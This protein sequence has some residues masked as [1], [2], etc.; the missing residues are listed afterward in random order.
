MDIEKMKQDNC[1]EEVKAL[2][3]KGENL[4]ITGGGGVGKSYLLNE[5]K[6][7]YQNDLTLTSTTGISAINISG[8]TL[9]SWAGIGIANKPVNEVVKSIRYKSSVFKQL[10]K[11]KIL[12]IDEV[13]MLDNFTIDYVNEVLKQ[14]RGTRLAFGGIQV[15]LVGDFFSYHLLKLTR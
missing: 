15:I 10:N 12:A 11:C 2:I 9:H 4:F 7:H 8:Q 1:F 3:D 14:V 6:K 13:S 5:L